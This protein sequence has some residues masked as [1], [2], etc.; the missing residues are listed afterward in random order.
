MG[1]GPGG[2]DQLAASLKEAEGL[3]FD[4][5]WFSDVPLMPTTDPVLAAT[6][7]ATSTSRMKIGA[8]FVPFGRAPYLFARQLAQ[9]D[10][11][12]GG[13]LLVTLVPGLDQPGERQA[14]GIGAHTAV[15]CSTT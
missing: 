11:L 14:L 10:R 13:R 4:T 6:I 9:L 7:A 8:N 15:A 2:A 1:T 12:S 5:V 3:G